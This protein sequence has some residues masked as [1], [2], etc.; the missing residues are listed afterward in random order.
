MNDEFLYQARPALRDGFA[1]E[2]YARISADKN[3]ITR[4]RRSVKLNPRR[5]LRF[6]TAVVI[7][8]VILI[9][10]AQQLLEPRNVQVGTMWVQE[11]DDTVPVVTWSNYSN[12]QDE[13]VLSGSPPT[14]ISIDEAIELLPYK[15][16]IPEWIPEGYSLS[17][18]V[19]GA[20]LSPS[21]LFYLMWSNDQNEQIDLLVHHGQGG[22]IRV[23]RG[24]WEE[25]S[26]NGLPA[27]LVRGDFPWRQL[28]PPDSPEW[29][30]GYVEQ[31]WD[32]NAGLKLIWNQGG[33][34]YWIQTFGD[35]LN[36]YDIIR[37]AESMRTW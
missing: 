5:A 17:Q 23:P 28:P 21:W 10:C 6:G 15:M 14:P 31:T 27:V 37:M 20:P 11:G 29:D 2:L 32:K 13:P 12:A 26:L 19:V 16:K 24:M 36:E 22:E 1:E 9:A 3:I 8:L 33:A 30:K 35:Y 25:V 4:L 18:D 34:R 7:G